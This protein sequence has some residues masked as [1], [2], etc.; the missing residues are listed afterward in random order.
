MTFFAKS[1]LQVDTVGTPVRQDL[2]EF[3][4]KA[5]FFLLLGLLLFL[6]SIYNY[7]LFH[8]LAEIF[9]IVIAFAVFLVSWNARDLTENQVLVYAGIAYLFISVL[10]LF[11]TLSY[12]GMDILAQGE[13]YSVQLWVAA[14]FMESLTLL[15]IPL[16]FGTKPRISYGAFFTFLGAVTAFLL[17]SI[18]IWD[19]FP[20]CLVPGACQTPFKIVSEY[21]ICLILIAALIHIYRN[22]KR[23]DQNLYLLISGAI[24]LTIISEFILTLYTSAY[25]LSNLVGHFLKIGSYYLIYKAIVEI[26]LR[27]P[28]K[29]IFSQL[30]EREAQ[31]RNLFDTALVGIFRIT[32]DGSTV[33]EANPA[34]A[35]IF[36]YDSPAKMKAEMVPLNCYINISDRNRVKKILD[37]EGKVDNLDVVVRDRHGNE[38]SLILSAAHYVDKGY[39]EGAILDNTEEVQ[40]KKKI[41]EAMQQEAMQQGKIEMA[42][43]VLHDIG[44][45][46]TA[47]G[48]QLTGLLGEQWPERDAM[49]RLQRL[50]EGQKDSLETA[51]G[52]GK[53]EALITFVRE[54]NSSLENR[55]LEFQG[56]V[57]RMTKTLGHINEILHLQRQY[58][59]EGRMGKKVYID[60]PELI[61]DAIA[62]H[63]GSFQKRKIKIRRKYEGNLSR[64]SGDRTR[65][66]QVFLNLLKNVCEAFDVKDETPERVIDIGIENIPWKDRIGITIADNGCGFSPEQGEKLFEKGYSTKNRN[67]G[68]GL[69]QCRNIVESHGGILSLR[70]D[71]VGKGATLLMELP[72]MKEHE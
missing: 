29:L 55:F 67:S 32:P 58:A 48:T 5:T 20:E 9:S 28:F 13:G 72:I 37:T 21:I 22:R 30:K 8:T 65:L 36:G 14:R 34:A 2:K 23:F 42:S 71:G 54:L 64:V 11:H 50:F 44:N 41:A 56:D 38:R 59:Q 10:D 39:T 53:G 62:I 69:Y 7:L 70:S 24:V 16:F 27:K 40:I 52:P 51:L 45:A 61:E 63:I 47:L 43:S 31:Y 66:L 15:G 33:L 46:V 25:N 57:E 68:I 18:F 26:G 17:M 35:K 49:E 1:G 3:L 12:S 6:I 19:I 4:Q 60:I